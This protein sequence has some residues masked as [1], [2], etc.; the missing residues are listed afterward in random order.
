MNDTALLRLAGKQHG[1][2]A[3]RQ[4]A[5]MGYAEHHVRWRIRVGLLFRVYRG[6]YAVAGAAD[7]FPFRVMAAVLAAGDGAVASHRCAAALFGLRRIH[8]DRPVITVSGRGAP[9]LAGIDRHRRDTLTAVD[10]VRVGVIP[11]TSPAWTLLDLAGVLDLSDAGERTRLGGALDDVLVR[12]LASLDGIDRL[13]GRVA[14]SRMPGSAVLEALVAERRAGRKPSETGLE[15]ELLEI[16]EAYGLPEPVRQYVLLLPGGG[17]ARFDA[18]YPDLLL[19]FEADGDAHHKG[20]LDR[21]R[22]QARDESCGLIG[23]RVRRYATDDI[24]SRPA[25]VADDVM[26]VRAEALAA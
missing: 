12:K 11:V 17:T 10:R 5:R 6:V 20:L 24:R 18:A 25:G 13:L 9:E 21:M 26:R 3:M 22:D 4:L 19:G 2:V 7:T 14:G 23:W 1:L 15:D 8:C 16:F